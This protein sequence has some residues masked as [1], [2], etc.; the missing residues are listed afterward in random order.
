[1]SSLPIVV[2]M[3]G[4]KLSNVMKAMEVGD[5]ASMALMVEVVGSANKYVVIVEV[6]Y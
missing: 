5:L 4:M 6:T 1:M 3:G 2:V